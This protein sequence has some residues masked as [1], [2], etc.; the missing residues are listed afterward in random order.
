[1]AITI[2]HTHGFSISWLSTIHHTAWTAAS[3]IASQ[4]HHFAAVRYTG[5]QRFATDP[6]GCL[7]RGGELL[8]I[9]VNFSWIW[10]PALKPLKPKIFCRQ[11]ASSTFLNGWSTRSTRGQWSG[12]VPVNHKPGPDF[13]HQQRDTY[14]ILNLCMYAPFQNVWIMWENGLKGYRDHP[15]SGMVIKLFVSTPKTASSSHHRCIYTG[16]PLGLRWLHVSFLK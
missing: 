11:T 3:L 16:L 15:F 8:W 12:L 4:L 13:P 14:N 1:M 9:L 7:Q 6:T 2:H 10:W 5:E